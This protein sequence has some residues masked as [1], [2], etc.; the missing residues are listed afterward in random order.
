MKITYIHHSAFLVELETVTLLFDYTEGALPEFE[1]NKPL[2]VFASHRHGD[3]YSEKILE[4]KKIHE[5]T[6]Y[7]LSADIGRRR[8]SK[9]LLKDVTAMKPDER[10]DFRLPGGS[11]GGLTPADGNGDVQV[12]TFRSTDE[13]VA[14]LVKAEGKVIY[15]AGDLNNWRWEGE[16]D[17]WN[18]SMAKK[19]S[20]EVDKM[21]GM[22]VDAAFLP[23][24]PRQ[25]G[26]FLLG[27]DEYMRKVHMSHAFPMH[28]W[29]DFSVIKRLKDMD[30]SEPYRDRIADIRKDG[31]SFEIG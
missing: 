2:L 19:Y 6:R 10:Q 11:S 20:A 28:C 7:I 25:G 8:L 26:A 15:H 3:H 16:P 21:A 5:N 27:F 1:N 24:D 30:I 22:H 31:E 18:D 12:L 17:S 14:F 23:L 29:G 13:G 9:E 4:F